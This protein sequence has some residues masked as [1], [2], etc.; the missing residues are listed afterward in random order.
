MADNVNNSNIKNGRQVVWLTGS[1]NGVGK[2]LTHCFY[3][4]GYAVVASD[5]EMATL[6]TV[7]K[8]FDWNLDNILL[9]DLNITDQDAWNTALNK[10]VER[11]GRIDIMF[12][13]AGY[14]RPGFLMETPP[15]ELQKHIDINLVGTMIGTQL[16]A[17]HMLTQ[18]S[19][20]IINIASLAA[21]GPVPGLGFYSAAKFGLR[22]Y[23]LALAH[24]LAEKNIAVSVIYPDLIKTRMLDLQLNYPKESAL[25]FT[26]HKPL[27]VKDIEKSVFNTVLTKRPMEVLLPT[28]RG[29]LTRFSGLFPE[30]AYRIGLK[31]RKKGEQKIIQKAKKARR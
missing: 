26:G 19:G 21:I 20:H 30:I 12:N 8:E 5:I 22:G 11:F 24:E 18:S 25:V 17:K 13:I 10:V 2:H 1:A 23:S 29:L 16:I 27:T 15:E 14:V 9:L 6:K 7:A 3:Q 28:H 31:I 4:K